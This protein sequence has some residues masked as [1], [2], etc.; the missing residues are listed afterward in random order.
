MFLFFSLQ[1]IIFSSNQEIKVPYRVIFVCMMFVFNTPVIGLAQL[2][3]VS[4][5]T[6]SKPNNI[7]DEALVETIYDAIAG[8]AANGIAKRPDLIG[9]QEQVSGSPGTAERFASTLNSLYSTSAY[10]S[11]ILSTGNFKQAY[12]FDSSAL[13]P[14]DSDEIFIGGIRPALFAQWRL[15]GYDSNSD[16]FTYNV[17]LKA[18]DSS[19]DLF[20]RNLSAENMR[21][22]ADALGQ[23]AHV[24][25]MGDFNFGGHDEQSFLTMKEPG[26]GQAFDPLSLAS[27][28][29]I[30]SRKYLTQSTRT[31]SLPDG[32]AFGGLDDR[33]DHQMVTEELLDGEGISYMGIESTGFAGPDDSYIAFGNDGLTF[34]SAINFTYTNREQ[35]MAVLDALHDFSDHLPVV[36]DFQLPAK[37]SVAI[38]NVP[39]KV[40]VDAVV[41]IDFTVENTAP[42]QNMIAADELDYEFVATGDLVGLGN[43]TDPATGGAIAESFSLDTSNIGESRSG[44]L[45][46]TASSQQAANA[47]D[48]TVV[49][50]DVLDHAQGSL[51]DS[52]V[53]T[54]ETIDLGSFAIGGT[55]TPEL[56]FEIYNVSSTFGAPLTA[57]LDLDSI[58]ENDTDD[59]FSISGMLF[60]NLEANNNQPFTINATADSLGNY[61]AV[62]TFNVSDENLPGATT[63][64]LTLNVSMDVVGILG[65]MDGNGVVDFGDI[66]P[67]VTAL[68]NRNDYNTMF[69]GIDADIIGDVNGDGL[70]D[71]GDIEPFVDL[72][73]GN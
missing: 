69:P 37:M 18:G 16:F 63:G 3:I 31:T 20:S 52:V 34:G 10:Q 56:E 9:L 32:G 46:V 48:D 57:K 64:L 55:I 41:D 21:A 51:S 13:S 67:F 30:Q 23:G 14:V 22:N 36:A 39:A 49:Q 6:L 25:Y 59:K 60:S 73:F 47:F 29:N 44:I 33:F 35:P 15:V 42:V 12:V 50:F 71:F 7:N 26:N 53:Q 17:H 1:L 45:M 24:I 66:E 27:W 40:I 38:D 19:G 54:T 28:P 68:F 8:R 5:N 61:S 62:F 65:D 2:R 58:D 4:Q 72:L 11:I 43:G 70:L